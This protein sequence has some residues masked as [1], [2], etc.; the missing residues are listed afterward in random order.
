M[1]PITVSTVV[2][3]P[4]EEVYE[5]LDVLANHEAFTDHFLTDWSVSGPASGV[6]AKV[7]VKAK[8]PGADTWIDIE[9]I[10]AQ[11]P[12][13]TVENA[14]SAGGKRRTCGTYTLTEL[15]GNRT[16]VQFEFGYLSAPAIERPALPLMRPWLRRANEKAMER[17]AE[18]L[19]PVGS[20]A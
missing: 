17:L 2:D 7:R 12:E 6:G 1:K 13:R 20:A 3:R 10:E 15:P 14:T 11:A 4:R 18:Q 8:A 5:Y 19:A 16:R 9:V